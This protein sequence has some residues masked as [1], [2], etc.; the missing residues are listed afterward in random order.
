M[1]EITR[2]IVAEVKK[3]AKK[4]PDLAQADVAKILGIGQ[5]TVSKILNGYYDEKSPIETRIPYEKF[6]KL[7]ACEA[8]IKEL[9]FDTKKANA[10]ENVL[11]I[12]Y[13][14]FSNILERF[15][16]EEYE[17]QIKQINNTARGAYSWTK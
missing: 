7:L 17:K 12:D 5:S 6:S 4:Y 1:D 8:A 14:V 10:G 15:L 3:Y 9:F 11:F 2:E 13:H 16:P